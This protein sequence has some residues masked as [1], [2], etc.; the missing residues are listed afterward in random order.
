MIHADSRATN[1]VDQRMMYVA[2]SRAKTSAAIYTDD[3]ARL[4]SA[5][6]ERAGVAQTAISDSAL[7]SAKASKAMGAGLG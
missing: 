1:L 7:S 3:R 2:V 5:I 6:H 4:V